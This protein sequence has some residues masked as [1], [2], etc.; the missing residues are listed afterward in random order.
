MD[1]SAVGCVVGLVMGLTRWCGVSP[2]SLMLMTRWFI[3][4]CTLNSKKVWSTL[5]GAQLEVVAAVLSGIWQ[6]RNSVVWELKLPLPRQTWNLAAHNLEAWRHLVHFYA[7][8]PEPDLR[9]HLHAVPQ[10]SDFEFTCW[11]DAGFEERTGRATFGA[12][13]LSHEGRFVAAM[14]G[15]LFDVLSP[16]MAETLACKET[17]VWLK[18][19]D[20]SNVRLFSDCSTLCHYLGS[21]STTSRAYIGISFHE[22]KVLLRTFTSCSVSFVPRSSNS[23]AHLL[24]TMA[25][26]QPQTMYLDSVPPFFPSLIN[27]I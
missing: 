12:V 2:G 5:D 21:A 1:L 26:S 25:Y 19:R 13:L 17:L 6:A 3:P 9:Q 10:G 24:A 18:A 11:F 16:L 7:P 4:L 27:H 22:C 14:N 15:P 23:L 8:P 20:T